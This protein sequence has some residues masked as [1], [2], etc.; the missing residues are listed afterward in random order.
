MVS[1]FFSFFFL[2]FFNVANAEELRLAVLE[3]T[4]V[5]SIEYHL[6]LQL[7]DNARSGAIEAFPPHKSNFLV[8]T[9]ENILDVLEK[10]GKE[11][12]CLQEQCAITLGRNI[13]SRFI[14]TGDV[15]NL[16]GV[17]LLKLSVYDTIDGN[18]L[19]MDSIKASSM[20][21]LIPRVPSF[22]KNLLQTSLGKY[23]KN[24]SDRIGERSSFVVSQT[25]RLVYIDAEEP[26]NIDVLVD[27]KKECNQIPCSFIVQ[28]GTHEFSFSGKGCTDVQKNQEITSNYRFSTIPTDDNDIEM[29]CSH[30]FLDIKTEVKG[31]VNLQ[32]MSFSVPKNGM[33]VKTGMH[34]FTFESLCFQ[35]AKRSIDIASLQRTQFEIRNLQSKMVK[36][37]VVATKQDGTQIQPKIIVDGT[38]YESVNNTITIPYCAKKMEL[39]TQRLSVEHNFQ[40]YEPM[41]KD[42]EKKLRHVRSTLIPEKHY[43]LA[44]PMEHYSQEDFLLAKRAYHRSNFLDGSLLITSVGTAGFGVYQLINSLSYYSQASSV[45]NPEQKAF[46]DETVAK[47]DS[48]MGMFIGGTTIAS[49]A[50]TAALI[51]RMISTK[52][53]KEKYEYIKLVTE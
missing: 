38:T 18:L 30:G 52:A 16:D 9:R 14:L 3:F 28:E 21:E 43:R 24:K 20:L 33:K 49:T 51:H 40:L 36:L 31:T 7:S 47:G 41:V 37:E 17:F 13:G 53:K 34:E 46:Y 2:I 10:E 39:V 29:S 22:S 12:G 32:G 4:S 50:L 5:S 35:D 23:E 27:K 8:L 25:K 1:Y 48:S 42:R 6:L 45:T 11:E 44:I 19:E 15:S 26:S